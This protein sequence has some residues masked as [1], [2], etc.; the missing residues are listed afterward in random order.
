MNYLS[1]FWQMFIGVFS[2][3]GISDLIDIAVITFLIYEIIKIARETQAVQLIKG[4]IFL[5]FAAFLSNILDL[6]TL[7]MI[8][9]NVSFW[10][11]L[12]IIVLFQPELRRILEHVGRANISKKVRIF[13]APSDKLLNIKWDRAIHKIA[14]AC[15]TLSKNR[16]GALIVFENQTKLGEIIET[17]IELNADVSEEL[18]CNIFFKN[19]PLHDG[20]VIVRNAEILAASCF[21]PKPAKEENIPTKLGTRHRAA[22]GMSEN[23]D[24]V[25]LVVSEETGAITIAKFGKLTKRL[26]RTELISY[27]KDEIIP[28][29]PEN[30]NKKTLFWRKNK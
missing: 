22:I 20:A 15:E 11:P 6:K 16:T 2:S 9:N 23:S 27:L 1:V 13:S 12:A 28:P 24:A 26:S 18:I 14:N 30:D 8:L 5:L 10:G 4:I 3:F 29:N 25:V 19:S 7:N 21:L 17:G